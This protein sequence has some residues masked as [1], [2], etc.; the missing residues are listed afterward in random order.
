MALDP[1]RIA[2]FLSLAMTTAGIA[3]VLWLRSA[4]S[5]RLQ[6][7]VDQGLTLRG[8]RLFG[9]N[10]TWRGFVVMVPA[11]GLAFWGGSR[12]SDT[13][14]WELS[15]AAWFALGLVSGLGFMLGELPNS[16]IKR[17][18]GVRPGEAPTSVVLAGLCL[19]LDRTD[20]LLGALFAIWLVVPLPALAWV[21]CLV[22][23]VGVHALFSWL[24]YKVGVKRR[25]A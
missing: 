5:Q 1:L 4:L 16:F 10:K 25:A 7:P 19:V 13:G 23:G 8:R 17:Q 15:A 6:Q 20:S 2:V 24:L 21:G 14:L 11:S 12:L 9:D 3:Q 22:V 18:A